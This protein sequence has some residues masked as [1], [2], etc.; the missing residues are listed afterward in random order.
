MRQS[1]AVALGLCACGVACLK[2]NVPKRVAAC[3]QKRFLGSG[4]S[5][6]YGV[7]MRFRRGISWLAIAAILLHAATIARHNV[8]QFQAISASL[9]SLAGFEPGALCHA[10]SETGGDEKAQT[11][12]GKDRERASKPCPVCLGLA[13]AHALP[14]SEAAS[15]PAPQTLLIAA[16]FPKE[17]TLEPLGGLFFPLSRGP[18]SLA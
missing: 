16:S 9:A 14:A 12:P 4:N 15:L 6:L 7:S 13:S 3:F 1:A 5:W 2:R 18:P 17:L 8:I 10:G 11:L